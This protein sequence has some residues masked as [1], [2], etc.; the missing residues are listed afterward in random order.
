MSEIET[1]YQKLVTNQREFFRTGKTKQVDFRI[2]A[3]KKLQS[4]IKNREAE[5]MEALKKDLNKS[6][7]E[8]YMTEIGMVLDE[9]RHCIAHVK[10]WSKPKSVKTPLAQFP[11]KSFTISEPYG[12][13]LIMSPWNYPFQLCIEPLIGAITAGNCAVL[14]PSAYAA[15]TSKVINTLIRACFPKE[16]VTVIEGGRK[17]NQGLLA[18]RF[19]YI[20]FTGGVEV[21]KIVMEA[22]AQF[23]TPV[24]LELGGKS[25]CIIEKSADIN[26]AAKRVAFGKYLNAGQTCVAPDYVFVQ[27]EVEEE[28]FKKLGL[29]VH[30]FFGEEPLKNENLP[31]IINEHHYHRLLSLLEGEDIVI[32]GKGQDNI[33]K[34]EPTV[35]KSV[36][37]DSNIMQEEIFGPILPVLS[38]KTIEE[39]IEYVTAHEKPLACYLF[40]TN[41]QIEKKVLKHVSF[42]GGCVNDTIIHLATPYMGF[43]GVGASGMG[44][45]HGFESFRTF[46]HTKSIVKKANWLDLPM[47]YHPYT[48]KNLKMIRKFLK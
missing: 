16:Y 23:L 37:T 40:T 48:E 47:R 12:V 32:G 34:I 46:S 15:E 33:R 18:T 35:L 4:E 5:I 24:S 36:S 38:Y 21:G 29:W 8:S 30:K 45:Y 26:L 20:F 39:V 22:A 27:K 3:L 11:S 9:I 42:G 14:K 43:G 6:S 25:P 19:D 17:E 2:Q 31:K 28:F 7:F 44:S 1:G 13:V 10:K 41:V